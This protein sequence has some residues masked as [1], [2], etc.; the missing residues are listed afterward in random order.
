[1]AGQQSYV[2]V[3]IRE[4]LVDKLIRTGDGE[5]VLLSNLQK[6]STVAASNVKHEHLCF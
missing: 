1:M 2:T 3:G 4:D 5:A 6:R